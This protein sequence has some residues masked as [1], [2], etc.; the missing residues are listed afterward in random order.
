MTN[1]R[2]L[3][4]TMFYNVYGKELVHR[5]WPFKVFPDAL[6]SY[7][8]ES[9][10]GIVELSEHTSL[11]DIFSAWR[12]EHSHLVDII[13]ALRNILRP[14]YSLFSL[15]PNQQFS[16]RIGLCPPYAIPG[17]EAAIVFGCKY[18]V[19]IRP[20]ADGEYEFLG[21]L[22]IHGYMRGAMIGGL[23]ETDI[24]LI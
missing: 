24:T 8:V 5:V 11:V 22:V 1:I 15:S 12:D 19:L 9:E 3:Y 13:S 2:A 4:E 23:P 18:P 17:Y 21:E 10:Y 16:T 20:K 7:N 6:L 14:E